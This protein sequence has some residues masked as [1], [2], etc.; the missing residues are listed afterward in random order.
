M[1]IK[2]RYFA[3]IKENLGKS[4]EEFEVKKDIKD[5]VKKEI[6]KERVSRQISHAEILERNLEDI[7]VQN[8]EKLDPHLK[9]VR[10]QLVTDVGRLDLLCSNKDYVVIELK[11]SKAGSSIIDQIS[12]Y[13]GWVKKNIAEKEGRGVRGI[14]VVGKKDTY[15]EYAAVA[16]PLIEIKVFNISFEYT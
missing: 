4:E 11:R 7:I 1:K 14:I 6:I 3:S 5:D 15:L 9:L 2:I 13:M 12:R 10:R 8:I 16:N